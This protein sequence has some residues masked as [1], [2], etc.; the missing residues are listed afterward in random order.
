MTGGTMNY[1][2]LVGFSFCHTCS[3]LAC[4]CS[5]WALLALREICHVQAFWG[6]QEM[7]K[8]LF[9][10]SQNISAD[11]YASVLGC[12]YMQMGQ[13]QNIMNLQMP[14]RIGHNLTL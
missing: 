14:M 12:S 7:G 2:A 5:R 10:V 8:G 9:Q 6:D 13:G 1:I 3:M 11:G 4:E